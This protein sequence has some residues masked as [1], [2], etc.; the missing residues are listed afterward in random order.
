MPSEPSASATAANTQPRTTPR[1][2]RTTV[3]IRNSDP[4]PSSTPV[5][6]NADTVTASYQY[7]ASAVRSRWTKSVTMYGAFGKN[8]SQTAPSTSL[9]ARPVA[10]ELDPVL[11]RIVKVDRLADAMVACAAER[12]ALIDYLLDSLRQRL[13]IRVSNG[14]VVEARRAARRR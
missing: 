6:A 3:C 10:V 7:G 8:S 9:V 4:N 13:A 5:H 2:C 11:I 1:H 12:N 14:D